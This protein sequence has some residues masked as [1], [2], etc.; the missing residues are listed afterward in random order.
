[1]LPFQAG[2]P[3]HFHLSW[4]TNACP[5][6]TVLSDLLW[7]VNRTFASASLVCE[8][9]LWVFLVGSNTVCTLFPG[10]LQHLFYCEHGR[11]ELLSCYVI[12]DGSRREH[13]RLEFQVAKS[14]Q[15][16]NETT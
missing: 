15:V 5:H 4:A 3:V 8:V 9:L 1:M 2:S 13:G 7:S 12:W 16:Y 14:L 6:R 11:S 10:S